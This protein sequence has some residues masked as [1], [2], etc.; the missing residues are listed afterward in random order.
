MIIVI[1]FQYNDSFTQDFEY[2]MDQWR[3][4]QSQYK[5]VER[6]KHVQS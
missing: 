4:Q 6:V 5:N 2:A 1:K 3:S